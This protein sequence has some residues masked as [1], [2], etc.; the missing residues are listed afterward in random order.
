MLNPNYAWLGIFKPHNS[1]YK[2]HGTSFHYYPRGRDLIGVDK[3]VHDD[4][5][6]W[7]R[8]EDRILRPVSI[9][10]VMAELPPDIQDIMIWN[11]H[12]FKD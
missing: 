9:D 11:I 10:V 8:G 12:R 5:R 2:I 6:W 7:K 3:R 4:R 1:G